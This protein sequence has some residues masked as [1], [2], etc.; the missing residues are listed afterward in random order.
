M[1]R[2]VVIGVVALCALMRPAGA[3]AQTDFLDWLEGLSGPGPFTGVTFSTR[4]VCAR[5]DGGKLTTNWCLN[6]TDANIKTV[7]NVEYGWAT[8][9]KQARFP[10]TPGDVGVI[11][12]QRVSATYMYRVSPMLDVGVGGGVLWLT[13]DAPP[14]ASSF[15][16]QVHPIFIPVTMTF[17]PLGLLHGSTSTKA[18]RILRIKFSERYLFREINAVDFKSASSYLRHGEFNPSFS[19][20]LDFWSFFTH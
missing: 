7:L 12:Q 4:T 11:H 1:K 14:P 15:D 18:G 13:G 19:I 9:G 2:V 8:T 6:D 10:D 16:A 5:D 3:F 17:T 20:G